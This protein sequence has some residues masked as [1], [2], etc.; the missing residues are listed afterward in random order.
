MPILLTLMMEPIR[1]SE[2]SVLTRAI[3]R[4]I[5]NDGILH[6]HRREILINNTGCFKNW[7]QVRISISRELY[8]AC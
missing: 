6:S 8:I 1:S 2:M 3:R 5:R 7:T 4:N